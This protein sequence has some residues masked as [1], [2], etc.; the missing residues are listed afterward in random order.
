MN[1]IDAGIPWFSWFLSCSLS[2]SYSQ[3]AAPQP[4]PKAGA[5]PVV[6]ELFTSEG[7]SSCPPADALL[8][9]IE[10]DQP[11]P[12]AEIIAIE[13]HVD[14]WNQQGWSDP[15]S[16]SEWTLRQQDYVAA[17]KGSTAYTPQMVVDG[18]DQ[19]IGSRS[20]D[21]LKA[22]R[23]GALREKIEILLIPEKAG[24]NGIVPI[25]VQVGKLMH[26]SEK[27]SAEV[28][29]AVTESGLSSA[30]TAGENS[31]KT[32][33]HASVLRTLRRIGAADKTQAPASF[34]GKS[35]V[36]LKPG[37]KSANLRVVV[38]VQERRS[39]RILGAASV[40]IGR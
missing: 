9:Q 5:A 8:A 23:D 6:V 35:G 14:Y 10:A 27:D 26:A 15:Y 40:A 20:G 12:G 16:A 11:V 7:C 4:A 17:F 25:S 18:Q 28:W 38:F 37:W 19:V 2:L 39:R 22:V 1:I 32:L 21:A 36:K 13:E 31:G 34:L 3:S 24:T 30:V 29:L 33:H